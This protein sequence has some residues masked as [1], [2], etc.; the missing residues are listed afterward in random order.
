[1]TCFGRSTEAA[2]LWR[3]FEAGCSLL[4][5]APHRI[6]KTIQ[7]NRLRDTAAEHDFRAIVLKVAGFREE[8]DFF[9]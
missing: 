5:P 7:I 1:M 9:R 3:S 8:I 2:V 4:I 6:G